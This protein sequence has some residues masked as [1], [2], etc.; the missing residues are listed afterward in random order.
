M[1]KTTM[2]NGCSV[3]LAAAL[4]VTFGRQIAA[5]P[6]DEPRANARAT[7]GANGTDVL[8]QLNGLSA[9]LSAGAGRTPAVKPTPTP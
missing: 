4:L 3:L 8:R 1:N 7:V 2:C 9:L 5:D 6:V